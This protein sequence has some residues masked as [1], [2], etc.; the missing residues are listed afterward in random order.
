MRQ[1][2][3]SG[4]RRDLQKYNPYP[5]FRKGQEETINQILD[6]LEGE[7]KFIDNPLPEDKITNIVVQAP[8]GSGKSVIAYIVAAYMA[9]N[10]YS[11]HSPQDDFG[12]MVRQRYK[13]YITTSL[14]ILMDQ[15]AREFSK[16]KQMAD[17]RGSDN[18]ICIQNKKPYSQGICHSSKKEQS[19]FPCYE[20]CP[21]VR[22]RAFARKHHI[23]LSNFHYLLLEFD[24]VKKFGPRDLFIADEAH[25]I[26]SIMMDYC[27][28]VWDPG[29][30]R[31]MNEIIEKM[32]SESGEPWVSVRQMRRKMWMPLSEDEVY[33]NLRPI[34]PKVLFRGLEDDAD[35]KNLFVIRRK[36]LNTILMTLN[37]MIKTCLRAVMQEQSRLEDKG[38]D[39]N[40]I[41][42]KLIE[43]GFTDLAEDMKFFAR[44]RCKISNFFEDFEKTIWITNLIRD[45]K[46]NDIE[47]FELKPVKVEFLTN[48][49]LTR[50]G[51]VRIFMSATICDPDQFCKNIGLNLRQT[52]FIDV[53]STFPIEHR[54]FL[55][56][57]MASMNQSNLQA[58]LPMISDFVDKVL[59]NSPG[60]KGIVHTVSYA[61]GNRLKELSKY[62]DRL[63][64]HTAESKEKIL[65]EFYEST[66]KVLV[67]PSILEGLDLKDNLSRFQ[68]FIKCPYPYLGDKQVAVRM[69]ME[70]EWYAYQTVLA[71][72]QGVGR[73]VRTE[74][75]WARTYMLDEGFGRLLRYN[76]NL[77]P[78]D[79]MHTIQRI[80]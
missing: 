22:A 72:V 43:G 40:Q 37:D 10:Y 36:V 79:F 48:E 80:Q 64:I 35:E 62:P 50:M 33:E 77:F 73:S 4:A 14:K 76:G 71:I 15:Y 21:Y 3:Y 11:K 49:S 34:D 29:N 53:P 59:E 27:A 42:D 78:E 46:T 23:T 67:S 7:I 61:N 6:I 31:K 25:N 8:T 45:E 39:D 5:T 58:N 28:V 51:D 9:E 68:V 2:E 54:P 1:I 30:I 74:E 57:P 44:L 17:I 66:D 75:D 41:A 52:A 38:Y 56:I 32:N 60:E 26:E 24:F 70:P 63:L 19:T 16:S 69:R 12:N 20:L 13:T 18:Y 55:Y 65:R 47:G